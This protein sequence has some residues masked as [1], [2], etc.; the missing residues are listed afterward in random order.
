MPMRAAR[1]RSLRRASAA[2]I[3]LRILVSTAAC[4][5]DRSP[6][7]R[8]FPLAGVVVGRE[9]PAGRVVI[10]HDAVDGFMPAMSMP[11][12]L[13]GEAPSPREGDRIVSTLVVTADRSWL[14]DLRISVPGA[15][16]PVKLSAGD[17]ALP[18]AML[19]DFHLRDQ[20]DREVALRQQA[21]RV[22]LITFLYTRCP[23][24]DLCPLMVRH[25]ERVRHRANDEGFG[26][27]VSLFG[28]T[29]DPSF[30]TPAV[31]RQ[32]GEAVFK[33]PDPFEQW[34]LA[35]GSAAQLADIAEYFGVASRAE[36]GFVT[37]T[38]TTAVV[39]HDGRVM[40]TFASNAWQPDELFDVVKRTADRVAVR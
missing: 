27:R 10:A 2:A 7:T 20:N 17:R 34:T 1:P 38:L 3:S 32:Y 30:D 5:R 21:G 13:R 4:S 39:G 40:R 8:R 33:G 36:G 28:I 23:L 18:G 26:S 19:P 11:F 37:H 35:T 31:L 9:S 24:P 14:E 12:E 16:A 25:L 22:L 6:D 29:L 15:V